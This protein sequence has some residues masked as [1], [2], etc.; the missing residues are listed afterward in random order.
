[1]QGRKKERNKN[2]ENREKQNVIN[3]KQTK[4]KMVYVHK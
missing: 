1:M 2:K 4:Q 3:K